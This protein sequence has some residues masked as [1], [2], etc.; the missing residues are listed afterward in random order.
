MRTLCR[1]RSMPGVGHSKEPHTDR[2]THRDERH[3]GE[4]HR[5]QWTFV[6]T[7]LRFPLAVLA[8]R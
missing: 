4:D 6:V 8:R 5:Q 7:S 1:R 2:D 3:D